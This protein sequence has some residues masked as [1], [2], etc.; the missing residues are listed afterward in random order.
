MKTETL[1]TLTGLP[2]ERIE[3]V[4]RFEVWADFGDGPALLGRA[5]CV[6]AAADVIAAELAG[7]DYDPDV[8]ADMP[9]LAG[10]PFVVRALV[11]ELSDAMLMQRTSDPA[12]LV[13][14]PSVLADD[15][16]LQLIV[17]WEAVAH[18]QDTAIG[19]FLRAED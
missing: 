14:L 13:Y 17:A 4:A 12:K 18:R 2:L 7:A 16:A 9:A 8:V 10:E 6:A 3:I 11:Y 5:D 1:Q 15:P 19:I